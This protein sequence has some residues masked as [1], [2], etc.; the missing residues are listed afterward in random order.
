[1]SL[2]VLILLMYAM[3]L[4]DSDKKWERETAL[5]LFATA[6]LKLY[7]AVFGILYLIKKRYKEAGRLVIYGF[8]LFFLP[9]IFF[10]GWRG[11][12]IFLHNIT[13]VGSG[14]TGVTIVGIC[15]RIAV[16]LGMTLKEGHKIGRFISY[17]YFFVVLLYCFF[18]RESWKSVTLLTSLMIIFVAASGTY[19][20]IYCVIPFIYFMNELMASNDFKR[21]D[22]IY[23]TLFVLIFAA[24]PI[25]RLGSSGMLYISL[26]LLLAVLLI[27][28][29]V[30]VVKNIHQALFKARRI[31]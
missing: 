2:L 27:E 21:V 14:A 6:A 8:I 19:C 7:P 1:M 18:K 15:G 13:A 20:L 31:P 4:K 3:I 28:Q 5:L 12:E 22:Y 10:D 25:H 23:A 17:I 24:Y 29:A 9:F 11:F 16:V 30:Q 26:Y